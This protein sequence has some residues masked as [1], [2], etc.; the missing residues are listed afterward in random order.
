[1]IH[2]GIVYR[3]DDA[4]MRDVIE[5]AFQGLVINNEIDP[6]YDR[7]FGGRLPGSPS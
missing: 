1:M 6:I 5:R 3:H 2:Y 7:W 4:P